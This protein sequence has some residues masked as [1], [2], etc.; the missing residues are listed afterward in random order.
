MKA[1]GV[2]ALDEDLQRLPI[3]GS[4]G[5]LLAITGKLFELARQIVGVTAQGAGQDMPSTTTA[6]VAIVTGKQIGRA[7]V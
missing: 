5:E 4:A 7:H 6:T 1:W 3:D 2:I